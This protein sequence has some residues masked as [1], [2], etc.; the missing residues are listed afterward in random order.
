M[1]TILIAD[2][3][4]SV[5]R[6]VSAT[7]AGGNYSLIE[8]R[9]GHEAL[10]L[11]HQHRPDMVLLDV[12]MPGLDGIEVCQQ[13]KVDSAFRATTIVILT[14][15]AQAD[16]RRRATEVGADVFLT[17]P[18]SPLQLLEIVEQRMNV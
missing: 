4:P 2:D 10:E 6:L 3:E 5:R 11:A 1:K 8:A 14:A 16:V 13:L 7:L 18:F 15:Q 12:S 9:D 17:K